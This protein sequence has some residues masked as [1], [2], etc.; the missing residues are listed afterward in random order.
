MCTDTYDWIAFCRGDKDDIFKD[1]TENT[2]LRKSKYQN[3][4]AFKPPPG[5]YHI[6]RNEQVPFST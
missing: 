1:C 2:L 3:F 5:L 4:E 6:K